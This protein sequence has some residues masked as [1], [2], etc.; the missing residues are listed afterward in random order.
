LTAEESVSGF[1]AVA[2]IVT[3]VKAEVGFG[4]K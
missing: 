1:P 3:I 4:A 2:G